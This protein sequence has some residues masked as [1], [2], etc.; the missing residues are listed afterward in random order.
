M[1]SQPTQWREISFRF[2]AAS[3]S[4]RRVF[5]RRTTTASVPGRKF[6][7]LAG[8][9][10]SGTMT[11]RSSRD[12]RIFMPSG[13]MGWMQMT[14]WRMQAEPSVDLVLLGERVAQLGHVE[15]GRARH[16]ED[17]RLLA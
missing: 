2:G 10:L 13:R 1:L 3:I 9:G 16:F 11:S 17:H 12:R 7:Q 6:A 4:A 8:S 5:A 15:A 14:L